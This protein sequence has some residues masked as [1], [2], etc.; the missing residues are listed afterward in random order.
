MRNKAAGRIGDATLYYDRPTG[1]YR[2]PLVHAT[3]RPY[4]VVDVMDWEDDA[5]PPPAAA[6]AL[7]QQST[8]RQSVRQSAGRGGGVQDSSQMVVAEVSDSPSTISAAPAAKSRPR[9]AR[10]GGA[11]SS[12]FGATSQEQQGIDAEQE[13][14]RARVAAVV[15]RMTLEASM[16]VPDL[17]AELS[18]QQEPTVGLDAAAAAIA[19]SQ[20]RAREANS[21]LGGALQQ[22]GPATAG[23]YDGP[24]QLMDRD[25]PWF[26]PGNW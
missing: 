4:D 2:D 3:A 21:G 9:A 19:A 16:S 5:P 13:E 1:R 8:T 15:Q 12:S 26:D 25:S 14:I 18:G 23:A 6:S 10:S 7:E 11:G 22:L 17:T 24:G 20:R